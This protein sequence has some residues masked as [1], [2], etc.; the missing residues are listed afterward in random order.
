ME[1][2]REDGIFKKKYGMFQYTSIRPLKNKKLTSDWKCVKSSPQN[3]AQRSFLPGGF[4]IFP[5]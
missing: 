1:K 2:S 3:F 4:Q 5:V